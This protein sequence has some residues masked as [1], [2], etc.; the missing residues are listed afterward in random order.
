[1]KGDR[2]NFEVGKSQNIYR[3][4]EG[5]GRGADP[6]RKGLVGSASAAA[7]ATQRLHKEVLFLPVAQVQCQHLSPAEIPANCHGW[8]NTEIRRLG[9]Q[10]YWIV[11]ISCPKFVSD[12]CNELFLVENFS[13]F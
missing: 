6:V 8:A 9:D 5:V 4:H 7:F 1:M 11:P 12:V 2:S 3:V 13:D 10:D